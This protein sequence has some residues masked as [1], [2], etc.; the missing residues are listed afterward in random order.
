MC[1]MIHVALYTETSPGVWEL[2]RSLPK[3]G[4][5]KGRWSLEKFGVERL[6]ADVYFNSRAEARIGF[7][8]DEGKRMVVYDERVNKCVS[9]LVTNIKKVDETTYH[10]LADGAVERMGTDPDNSVYPIA[11]TLTATIKTILTDHVDVSSSDQSHIDTN[12]RT[13]D[14][15]NP[16]YPEGSYPDDEIK[17]LLEMRSSGGAPWYFYLKDPWIGRDGTIGKWVPYYFEREAVPSVKWQVWTDQLS[18][19][20]LASSINGII[21][22]ATVYYNLVTGTATSTHTSG[23]RLTD[24]GTDFVALGVVP[25]DKV[26]NITDESRSVVVDVGD[27]NDNTI[28]FAAMSGGTNGYFSSGDTWAIELQNPLSSNSATGTA[29]HWPRTVTSSARGQGANAAQDVADG[30][31]SLEAENSQYI[32]I[33]SPFVQDNLEGRWPVHE[34]FFYGSAWVRLNDYHERLGALSSPSQSYLDVY[35]IYAMDW[36]NDSGT[37]KL[38][39]ESATKRWD[40]ILSNRGFTPRSAVNTK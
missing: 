36:D 9:A 12:S 29:V 3:T 15:W 26:T 22:D 14:G 21:S 7:E 18:G 5:V 10:Y 40:V 8:S 38:Q 33:G 23:T 19:D 1:S 31:I 16:K 17:E 27:N 2:D 20:G 28:T 34:V 25:G 11:N 30:L 13:L 35:F 6:D 37:V 24:T 39:L 4:S 32:S